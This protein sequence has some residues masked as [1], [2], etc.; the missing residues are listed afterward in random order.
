MD[1]GG[2]MRSFFIKLRGTS[3]CRYF[4][5]AANAHF[6]SD[7]TQLK[8]CAW[9]SCI[10]RLQYSDKPVN[11]H[12]AGANFTNR[13]SLRPKVHYSSGNQ[14]SHYTRMPCWNR[15]KRWPFFLVKH[16]CGNHKAFLSYHNEINTVSMACLSVF[17]CSPDALASSWPEMVAYFRFDCCEDLLC[18]LK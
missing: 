11:S 2:P 6:V 12:C 18:L 16:F 15:L 14:R 5:G 7:R 8:R 4:R 1:N 9:R 17:K 3:K 10:L 13:G